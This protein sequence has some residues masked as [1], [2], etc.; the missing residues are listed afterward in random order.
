MTTMR[1]VAIRC[2]EENK[3]IGYFPVPAGKQT[4][5]TAREF[6][7]FFVPVANQWML[8]FDRQQEGQQFVCPRCHGLA[9]IDNVHEVKVKAASPP[10]GPKPA[11]INKEQL[12]ASI[13]N[14]HQNAELVNSVGDTT[15]P[16]GITFGRTQVVV[17]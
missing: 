16:L 15:V 5:I 2:K 14:E 12:L 4:T 17:D 13:Q 1:K 10:V 11:A 3:I 9:H 8:P 6:W 7:Q